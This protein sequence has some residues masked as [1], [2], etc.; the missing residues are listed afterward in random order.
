MDDGYMLNRRPSPRDGFDSDLAVLPRW[1]SNLWVDYEGL[2]WKTDADARKS[3]WESYWLAHPDKDSF[4]DFDWN[5]DGFITVNEFRIMNEAMG[6][7]MS[8]QEYENAIAWLDLDGDGAVSLGEWLNYMAYENF[9]WNGTYGIEDINNINNYFGLN[10]TYEDMSDL[11][12]SNTD[13]SNDG[14]ID[15]HDFIATLQALV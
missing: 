13:V 8:Q 9:D 12:N 3:Y 10:L 5:G 11:F 15:Y 1:P 4:S 2:D 6:F 14:K 7:T